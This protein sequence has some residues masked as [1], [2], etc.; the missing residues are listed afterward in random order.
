MTTFLELSAGLLVVAVVLYDVFETIVV[1][2]RTGYKW[3][4]APPLIFFLWP[5]WRTI[6]LRLR[7]ASRREDFLGTFAPFVIMLLLVV[8]VVSLVLGYGLIFHA[9]AD[10]IEPRPPD[11]ASA[12]YAA[13]TALLT[14]GFGDFVPTSTLARMV[15]LAA[16]AA[17]LGV[18]ALVIS[19][20]FNL[21]GSFARREVLVLLLDARA[22]SPPSGV[23]LLET[24]AQRQI[25]DRLG[26]TF[27]K[28]ESWTAELLESHLAYPILPLFRSSHDGQSWISALGAVLDA[29]TLLMT[30][31]AE[32]AREATPQERATRAAAEMMYHVGC[33]ALVDLTE[34]R[35]ARRYA[36]FEQS[37]GIERAEFEQACHQLS[38]AGF[39][40][41][42]DD[43]AWQLF[44]EHRSVYAARL[45]AL[46][47]YLASPPTQWIGD[48][49][50]LDHHRRP[51]F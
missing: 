36:R 1:P 34:F 25:V 10:Q 50:I 17:G 35:L 33:H 26:E 5:V 14:I 13:G 49:T 51:H 31:V 23:T 28:Y 29:A 3:R 19:L 9:L 21:Y 6:G 37:V 12:V 2:R 7:P 22:G 47:R 40:T 43:A 11:F 41:V 46:A 32:P 8:W 42:C 38:C 16:G 44:V 30:V 45:N 48:R 24:Y 39:H 18:V 20:T 4:L 15:T 27:G